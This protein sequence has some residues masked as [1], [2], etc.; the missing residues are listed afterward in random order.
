MYHNRMAG[1]NWRVSM[2]ID[3]ALDLHILSYIHHACMMNEQWQA[4]ISSR[5]M[6]DSLLYKYVS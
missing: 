2:G 5:M 4:F 6:T 1:Q 3:L